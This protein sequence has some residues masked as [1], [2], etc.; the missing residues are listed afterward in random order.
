M[1]LEV[2]QVSPALPMINDR[3]GGQ[4]EGISNTATLTF[5]TKSWCSGRLPTGLVSIIGYF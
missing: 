2:V 1:S 4:S 5:S 3:T